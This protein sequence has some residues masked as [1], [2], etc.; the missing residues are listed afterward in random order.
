MIALVLSLFTSPELEIPPSTT[1]E[2]I[3]SPYTPISEA[4]VVEPSIDTLEP[5]LEPFKCLCVAYARAIGMDLPYPINA[6]ELEP[7]GMPD[8]GN[9]ILFRYGDVYHLAVI[10]GFT[11]EGWLVT[12]SNKES[13]T[14]SERVVKWDDKFILG[15]VKG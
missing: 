4:I 5:D 13:C 14:I 3:E 2:A 12:E 11:D 8:I 6:D 7:N 10:I 9:G 15:F 1:V